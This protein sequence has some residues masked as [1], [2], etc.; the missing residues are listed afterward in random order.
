[1]AEARDALLAAGDDARAA[2]TEIMLSLTHRMQGRL[3]LADAYGARALERVVDAPSSRSRA[4]VLIRAAARASLAG[5]HDKAMAMAT[6]ALTVT[7][8]LGWDEGISEALNLLGTERAYGGD[9][10]AIADLERSV[11]FA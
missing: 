4:W 10:A 7:E 6:E 8:A 3:D 1:L 11:E 5:D 9:P 2:E